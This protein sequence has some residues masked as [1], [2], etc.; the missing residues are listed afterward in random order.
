MAILVPGFF[1]ALQDRFKALLLYLWFAFFRPQD[2]MWV[3]ISAAK[4]SLLLGLV[5]VVPALL[6]GVMPDVT[7]PLSIGALLFLASG[8]AAQINAINAQ[9]G[10]E[11]IDFLTRLLLVCL[12][13]TTL[14]TT[15]KRMTAVLA[16]VS[17]SFG[18]HAA[19]AGL[20]SVLGGG[21]RFFDGLSGAFVDNNGYA[22]GTVMIMPLLVAAGDNL[23]LL[24]VFALR[25][26]VLVWVRRAFRLAV[27][28]CAVTVVSTYS[29][30]GFLA[31]AAAG[32]IY[33]ALHRR[34]V[35]L[36]LG[37]SALVLTVLVFVPLPDGYAER[38][39]TI[40]TYEEVGDDSAISRTHFWQ[41][42]M[43][44]AESQPLGIGLRN[45][46]YGY[47]TYDF[48]HGRYGS[49]RAVHSS[50]FQ[51]LA[52]MG[53]PG[54][55]VWIGEFAVAFIVAMRVRARSRT[56]GLAPESARFLMSLANCSLA[57]MSGFLVGGSFL[58]LA[59]NDIT[60]L[61]FALLASADRISASLVAEA[62][63]KARD[64]VARAPA[65]PAPWATP[66]AADGRMRATWRYSA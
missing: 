25:P 11:W 9:V 33:I 42:A 40:Q 38:L 62:T 55:L 39:E 63:Q 34:R 36:A 30:G 65:T 10:L 8:I 5:L 53:Y 19:K 24:D 49:H 66:V 1:L 54:I 27:P 58:G 46:E 37:V 6:T 48:S 35:R 61:T 23:G 44:M 43:K 21:V 47:D 16:V 3:D 2:W 59:L 12:L 14:V 18:F 50:H 51:V 52:E 60:W 41:V 17:G 20:A 29:R 56:P 13:A 45:F 22:C 32:L 28:L 57:S 15:P 31:L 4:P 26:H 7:H 64:D